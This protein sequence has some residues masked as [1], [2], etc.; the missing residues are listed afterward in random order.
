MHGRKSWEDNSVSISLCHASGNE[1]NYRFIFEVSRLFVRQQK[2]DAT[3]SVSKGED[4][5]KGYRTLDEIKKGGREYVRIIE[6]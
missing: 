3:Y 2:P 6:Q 1:Y 4:F 5:P